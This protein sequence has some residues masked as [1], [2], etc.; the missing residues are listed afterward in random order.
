MDKDKGVAWLRNRLVEI[1]AERDHIVALLRLYSNGSSPPAKSA[2]TETVGKPFKKRP[3]GPTDRLLDAVA[4]QPGLTY[5]KVLD[6]AEQGMASDAENPRASL[7]STLGSLVKRNKV[8]KDE[9][10]RYFP[11]Y[12]ET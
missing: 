9:H 6:L 8:R 2:D 10:G 4:E 12:P 5:A 11:V 1:D 3:A 7:G